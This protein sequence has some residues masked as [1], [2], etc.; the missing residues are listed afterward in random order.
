V[1]KLKYFGDRIIKIDSEKNKRAKKG[2]QI[3]LLLFGATQ[4]ESPR[5]FYDSEKKPL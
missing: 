4:H 1:K 2:F 5:A 3:K